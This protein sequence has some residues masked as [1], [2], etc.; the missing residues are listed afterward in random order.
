MDKKVIEILK[1]F[2]SA[3]EATGIRVNRMI[4]FGSYVTG[5]AKEW[6]DIDVAVISE[7]FKNMNLLERLETIGLALAKARIMEPVEA[8]GYTEKEF[9]SKGEGTFVGDEIKTKGVEVK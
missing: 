3:L 8:R 9:N 1:T 6:S 5:E 2:K 7:D 4:L